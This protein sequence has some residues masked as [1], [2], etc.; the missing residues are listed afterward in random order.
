LANEGAYYYLFDGSFHEDA[1]YNPNH[2][3]PVPSTRQSHIDGILRNIRATKAIAPQ[4]ITEQHDMI[5]GPGTPRY[6]PM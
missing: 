5:I 4:V 3:H 1:C 6:T 2:G